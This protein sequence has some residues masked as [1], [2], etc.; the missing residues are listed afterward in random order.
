LKARTKIGAIDRARHRYLNMDDLREHKK[1][2]LRRRCLT[3]DRS[4]LA[5]CSLCQGRCAPAPPVR[6]PSGRRSRLPLR[7]VLCRK[8]G[9]DERMVNFD[10]T[11]DV[12]LDLRLTSARH[13]DQFAELDAH[14]RFDP[15]FRLHAV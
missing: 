6:P 4:S 11:K 5:L 9:L 3:P 13:D 10:R 1:E 15:G 7:A 8:A 2:V 14:N 12:A